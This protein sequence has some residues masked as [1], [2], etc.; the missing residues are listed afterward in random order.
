MPESPVTN[1][2]IPPAV[3]P[4]K[5]HTGYVA[6]LGRPNTGKSTFLNTVL[7]CHLAAVSAK[8]QTTRKSMLGIYNDADSQII[9]LDAPGVHPY[10]IALD[11]AMS[12]AVSKVTT[13]A[14]IIVCLIDPTRAPGQEDGM[15]AEIASAC[16]KPVLLVLNK[17]DVSTPAQR[18]ASLDF[19]QQRLQNAETYLMTAS[20][21]ASAQGLID[22]IK[23]LLPI[24]IYLYDREEVTTAYERD[25]A[26][27]LIRETILEKLH[28]EIPHCIAVTVDSW[29]TMAEN[30]FLVRA[31]LILEREAHKGIVIGRGG[32][33]IKAIRRVSQQKISELCQGANITL[34]LTIKVIPNWRKHKQ[35]LKDIRLWE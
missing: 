9:F 32:A 20:D 33:M 27:E 31:T 1:P 19:Y 17:T 4:Q 13:D 18:Q 25:I 12:E 28:D 16:A 7:G 15:V 6:L 26:A 22:R 11:E 5:G 35:F 14:D 34:E 21:A 3:Q 30:D 29:K 10:R 8:P 2:A 23:A 24:D